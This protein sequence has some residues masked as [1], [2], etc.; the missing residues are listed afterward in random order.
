MS[1]FNNIETYI[2]CMWP[3]RNYVQKKKQKYLIPCE[4]K[5]FCS[6]ILTNNY[7]DKN[8]VANKLHHLCSY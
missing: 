3:I 4:R 8:Y 1:K 6:S 2:H 5:T 7:I